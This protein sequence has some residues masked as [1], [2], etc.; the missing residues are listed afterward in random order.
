VHTRDWETSLFVSLSTMLFLASAASTT[1]A[2]LVARSFSFP[3][4]YHQHADTCHEEHCHRYREIL[5]CR[6]QLLTIT[7]APCPIRRSRESSRRIPFWMW[8]EC[9]HTL[10]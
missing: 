3:Q 6:V 7:G 4:R 2:P 5:L 1:V 10:T 9:A 8:R